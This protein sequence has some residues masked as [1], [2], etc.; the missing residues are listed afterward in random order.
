M[1]QLAVEATKDTE[2]DP[3][4]LVNSEDITVQWDR[5]SSIVQGDRVE[6]SITVSNTGTN[7]QAN[8]RLTEENGKSHS[9]AKSLKPGVVKTKQLTLN[10]PP[11]DGSSFSARIS[12]DSLSSD[13]PV[14]FSLLPVTFS[15]PAF[16]SLLPSVSCDTEK[17]AELLLSGRLAASKSSSL[18]TSEGET[19]PQLA[20]TLSRRLRLVCVE[21]SG[22]H[23]AS[24]YAETAGG[25]VLAFLLKAGGGEAS[26]EGRAAPEDV[27]L[28]EDLMAEARGVLVH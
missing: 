25:A 26:L 12:S 22:G 28:L 5:D 8:I 14:T 11:E 1:K 9:L 15:L 10:I 2:T 27:G 17:F 24:F 6:L 23:T 18:Q 3:T 21:V 16:A 7:K 13:L 19:V 20:E 4:V